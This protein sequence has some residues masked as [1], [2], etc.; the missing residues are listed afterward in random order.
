MRTSLALSFLMAAIL[1]AAGGPRTSTNYSIAADALDAGGLPSSSTSYNQVGSAGNIAGISQNGS[2]SEIAKHGYIG[3]LY[4]FTALI[5]SAATTNVVSGSNL[6]LTATAQLDDSTTLV[7]PGTQVVWS[8]ANGPIAGI[9]SNGLAT[10][11]VVSQNTAATVRGDSLGQFGTL[12]LLVL[13]VAGPGQP[14]IVNFFLT[15]TNAVLSGTN[16]PAGAGY[17]L[18]TTTNVVTPLANWTPIAAS[19]FDTNGNFII[20][21]PVSPVDRQR[22]YL[23][24][25]P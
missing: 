4:D 23:I 14:R 20:T 3:Q 6:Q 15:G 19:S 2:P 11:G 16:G 5:V 7:L 17:H 10:A 22:F 24:Q 13:V 1:A 12:Q 9:N 18:L 25:I 8:V 21:N